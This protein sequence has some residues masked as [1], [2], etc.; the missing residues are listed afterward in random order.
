MSKSRA[1]RKADT[2]RFNSEIWIKYRE[3]VE[4]VGYRNSWQVFCEKHFNSR[5]YI[6]DQ[7]YRMRMLSLKKDVADLINSISIDNKAE[8]VK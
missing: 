8:V 7:V 4:E 5:L 1:Q 3:C 2:A 6:T